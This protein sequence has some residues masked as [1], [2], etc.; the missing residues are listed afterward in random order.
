MVSTH[1]ITRLELSRNALEEERT[2]LNKLGSLKKAV[3]SKIQELTEE[4]ES[5]EKHK[6]RTE[7]MERLRGTMDEQVRGKREKLETAQEEKDTDSFWKIG[8]NAVEEAYFKY[9]GLTEEPAKKTGGRGQAP[10]TVKK[11]RVQDKKKD[12]TRNRWSIEAQGC[13]KQARRS[14]QSAYKAAMVEKRRNRRN[15]PSVW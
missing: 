2:M 3:G 11:P 10:V 4:R 6:R 8:S 14:E 5:K 9:R 12:T 1:S 15:L 13:L 7:E